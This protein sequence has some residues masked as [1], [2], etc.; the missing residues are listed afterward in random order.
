MYMPFIILWLIT[1]SLLLVGLLGTVIPGLPG[2]G[3]VYGGILLYAFV[4]DFAA[5]SVATVV[6]LGFVA[7]LALVTDYA[8]SALG[9]RVGG[10]RIKA[11]FGAV[12]GTV[13]GGVLA[14]PPGMFAGA[15][16]GAYAGAILQGTRGEQALKIAGLSVIGIVGSAA[17][18]FVL[19][20]AMIFAFILAIVI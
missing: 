10:G 7:V 3:F 16:L 9:A 2:I 14:G 1:A 17:V 20:L 11:I 8:G 18:Q 5:I 19:A 13:I 15:F 4:T 6:T 12:A